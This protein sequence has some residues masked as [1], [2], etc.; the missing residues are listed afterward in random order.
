MPPV[1]ENPE[2]E[3]KGTPVRGSRTGR[4]SLVC[5]VLLLMSIAF[6]AAVR[7]H[8]RNMPLERDEGEYAYVGQ[9]M[10]HGIPPYK[11]AANMKLPGSY[12]AYAGIMATFGQTTAGIRVGMIFVTS[13][14]AL[15]VFL[16]GKYLYGKVAGTVAG[17]A[18]ILLAARPGV[19][20]MDGHAT[21][22]VVLAALGGILLL[23]HAID[24]ASISLFLASGLLLGV[25]FLMKQPGIL[26]AVFA[27]TY[28][29]V[30]ER[31]GSL[32]KKNLA[33]RGAVLLL[34]TALPYILTCLYL[35]RAGV[36]G[37]FWF[38]TWDYARAYGSA[39]NL[40]AGWQNLKIALPW[41][42]RPFVLW[43]L[44]AIGLAAPLWSR[45]GR[46]RG[47]FVA[48]FFL[49]SCIAVCP[50]LYFRPHYFIV[51]L[52]AASLCIGI[53]VGCAQR[54]LTSRNWSRL[55]PLPV[56]YFAV[57]FLVAL[58][59]QWKTF[60]HLD[61]VALSRAMHKGEPYAD[62]VRAAD[63]IAAR[64]APGDQ[65]GILGS[66]PEICFYTRLRC[67]SSFLYVY[68]LM[69]RQRFAR[70]MQEQFMQEMQSSRPRFLVYVDDERSWG[71]KPTLAEN[72]AFLERAW[73][74]AN[75]GYDLEFQLS[76]PPI[77]THGGPDWLWDDGPGLY[78]FRRED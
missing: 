31:T 59:G 8:F 76:A 16:L 43:E 22:F 27:V 65:I 50:G 17:I 7:F 38:W 24:R 12:A 14:S 40:S 4:R 21:H 66:E 18:Y 41:A 55:T 5:Y 63:F 20:G 2:P 13:L 74:F 28:W 29:L 67:A 72:R 51:L 35:L 6:L 26:F 32:P 9:L 47:G 44:V 78:V 57:S 64:A 68:P 60:A 30:R 71:W 58:A 10:L 25:A 73:A 70:R 69:E 75:N 19:M 49:A 23:L 33:W 42:V 11:L 37:T 39:N 34:C 48:G 45:H 3:L 52:P 46:E 36:F 77:D 1:D 15:L 53:A 56:L 62:A 61:P 54:E